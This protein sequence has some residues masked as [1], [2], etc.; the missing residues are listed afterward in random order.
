MGSAGRIFSTKT[1][2][3]T[4]TKELVYEKLKNYSGFQ[5]NIENFLIV[6]ENYQNINDSHIHVYLKSKKSID[7]NGI[8]SNFLDLEKLETY[9]NEKVKYQKVD[10]RNP[11]VIPNILGLLQKED[12]NP[13]T[14]FSESILLKSKIFYKNQMIE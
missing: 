1:K 6:E 9:P 7:V 4:I 5:N 10:T 8:Y 11:F 13:L 12:L 2:S 3:Q 14:N